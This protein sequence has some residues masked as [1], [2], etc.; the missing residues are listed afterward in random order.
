MASSSPGKS[1]IKDHITIGAG[2][3]VGAKTGVLSDIPAGA[4]VSG[5]YARPHQQEMRLNVHLIAAARNER[6]R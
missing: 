2:A 3:I 5:P 1:G 6:S 4:F